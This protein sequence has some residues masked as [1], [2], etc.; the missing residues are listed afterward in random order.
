MPSRYFAIATFLEYRVTK[1]LQR[2]YNKYRT[3]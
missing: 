3:T 2:R 1:T